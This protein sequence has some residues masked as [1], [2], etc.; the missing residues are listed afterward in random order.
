MNET[1][2]IEQA[3]SQTVR[4]AQSY[5]L[6]DENIYGCAET[7]FMALKGAYGI[8]DPEGS[9]AAMALNG[10]VAYGG[11]ICGAITGAA[12]A[13]GMLAQARIQDH[14]S[15]KRAAR[16]VIMGYMDEFQRVYRSVN[17]VDL[18]GLNIRDEDQHRQFIESGVWRTV[19]MA[20]IEFAIRKL[21]PLYN[22]KIWAHEVWEAGRGES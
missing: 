4:K 6:T 18:I 17:C 19:C 20:Q 8:A 3:I 10:G 15:A 7:T 11:S 5:F 21:A 9:A 13:V 12:M 22:R 14:K 2:T 1:G 16:R